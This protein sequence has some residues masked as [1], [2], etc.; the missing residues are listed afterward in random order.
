MAGPAYFLLLPSPHLSR[1]LSLSLSLIGPACHCGRSRLFTPP[2]LS[3]PSPPSPF[4]LFYRPGLSLWQVPPIYSPLLSKFFHLSTPPRLSLI[5]PACHCGRSL[6][7]T[8]QRERQEITPPHTPPSPIACSLA[9]LVIVAGP[10]LLASPHFF[11]SIIPPF[12][13][14]SHT[15]P[16]LSLWQVPP[17]NLLPPPHP[18]TYSPIIPII[19]ARLVIV[20]GPAKITFN[21]LLTPP[22]FP[23][24]LIPI[25]KICLYFGPACHCGRSRLLHPPCLSLHLLLPLPSVTPY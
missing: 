20:A 10:A 19:K 18:H 11:L 1:S 24:F 5:G 14:S 9:R 7:P 8:S 22:A 21:P 6:C 16:G 15:W 17:S 12:S 2:S 3:L 13:I 25:F 4:L 23:P